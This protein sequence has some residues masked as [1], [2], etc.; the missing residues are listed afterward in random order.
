MLE[1]MALLKNSSNKLRNNC[2]IK[3]LLNQPNLYIP[4]TYINDYKLKMN[5][6]LSKV[7]LI[8]TILFLKKNFSDCFVFSSN[9]EKKK[10]MWVIHPIETFLLKSMDILMTWL[11]NKCVLYVVS[12]VKYSFLN[13]CID[14]YKSL[15]RLF[16]TFLKLVLWMC[17]L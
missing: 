17:T 3:M 14:I 5:K 8:L 16:V 13:I 1:E 6:T 10:H 7:C 2:F 9:L 15:C 11:S 4:T 12:V